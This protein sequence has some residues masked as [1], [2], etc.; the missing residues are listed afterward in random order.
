MAGQG[1]ERREILRAMAIAA[2]ASSFPGFERWAFAH[3]HAAHQS[4]A[5]PS[6]VAKQYKPQFFSPHEYQTMTILTELIIPSDET[7]GAREA[8]VGEFI[9]FMA[10]SDPKVQYRFRYGLSWLDAHALRL[11]GRKFKDMKTE[12]QIGILNHF[13]YQDKHREGEE[14]GRQ[15]FKLMRDYTVMGF[16]TTR[17][18]M[19]QLDVPT[20]KMY[21]SSPACPH[22]DDPEHKRLRAPKS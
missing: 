4:K 6:Q 8:G 11:H 9:D 2:A 7:P 16:Y 19:Q 22:T 13:A 1:I 18:G 3:D 12:Q 14:H 5:D 17:I 10:A 21:A 15:F 20:L